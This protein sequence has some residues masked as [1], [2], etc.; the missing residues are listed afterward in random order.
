MGDGAPYGRDYADPESPRPDGLFVSQNHSQPRRSVDQLRSPSGFG[1]RYAPPPPPAPAMGLPGGFGMGGTGAGVGG[2]QGG[3]GAG[4]MTRI[5]GPPVYAGGHVGRAEQPGPPMM[6]HQPP[7]ESSAPAI[8]Q[9]LFRSA[10]P[11]IATRPPLDTSRLS[12]ESSMQ[13]EGWGGRRSTDGREYG[14]E[15]GPLGPLVAQDAK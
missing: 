2:L 4:G 1:G 3:F 15:N 14:H 10:A 11:Q 12:R 6:H 8:P 9:P 7:L 5:P 13:S